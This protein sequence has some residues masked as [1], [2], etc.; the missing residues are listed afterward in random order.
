MITI[1]SIQESACEVYGITLRELLSPSREHHIVE[2]RHACMWMMLK[3]LRMS[4]SRIARCL[5]RSDHTTAIH[6]IAT[7]RQRIESNDR[8]MIERIKRIEAA[9]E[10]N[11]QKPSGVLLQREFKAI[12]DAMQNIHE[13]LERIRVRA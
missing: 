10:S 13:L 8:E 3:H 4:R 12:H 5:N 9:A 11:G 1:D 7:I 2:A 6:G